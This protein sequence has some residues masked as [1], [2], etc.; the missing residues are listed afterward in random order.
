MITGVVPDESPNRA[1]EDTVV[2][3]KEL[4]PDIPEY[5]SNTIMKGMAL[6]PKSRFKNL[7]AFSKALENKKRVRLK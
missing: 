1:I 2:S 4:N 6:E 3:P 7:D 5:L